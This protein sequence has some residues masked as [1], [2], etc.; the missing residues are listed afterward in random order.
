MG[1]PIGLLASSALRLLGDFEMWLPLTPPS[2]PC[3]QA[4]EA[5]MGYTIGLLASSVFRLGPRLLPLGDRLKA[6][7]TAAFACPSKVILLPDFSHRFQS[8][9]VQRGA[10]GRC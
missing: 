4:Q 2:S 3:P 7:M 8:S 6:A 9:L 10:L 5:A 1:Y